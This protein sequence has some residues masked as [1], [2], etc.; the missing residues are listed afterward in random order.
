[1][2]VGVRGGTLLAIAGVIGLYLGTTGWDARD[3]GLPVPAPTSS[4]AAGSLLS[5]TPYASQAYQIWPGTPSAA[6]RRAE[7]GLT[8]TVTRSAGGINVSIKSDGKYAGA[9]Y[10]P[11][12]ARVYVISPGPGNQSLVVTDAEGRIVA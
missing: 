12:G 10:Y 7:A 6:A 1:M 3:S 4:V 2:R 11:S 5:S 9:Q 8:V